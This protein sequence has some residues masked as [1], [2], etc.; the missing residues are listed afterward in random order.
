MK[1]LFLV[2]SFS[3]F[4][5]SNLVAQ[6]SEKIIGVY[7]NHND[8]DSGKLSYAIDCNI[9]KNKIILNDLLNKSYI[10]IKRNDSVY[11]IRKKT[12]Y[13][14]ET[15]GTQVYRFNGKRELLLLNPGEEILI[16]KLLNARIADD[17]KINVTNKYFCIND[18]SSPEK[19]T[20][21]NLKNAFTGNDKFRRLVDANFKYNMELGTFDNENHI[22]KIN[23]LLKESMH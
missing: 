22:F 10:T 7:E 20:I 1:N 5:L 6:T 11:K 9:G 13:G 18:S 4:L 17:S 2:V 15:C 21:K 3:S 16:Y 8:F 12:L 19:L 14:Y 23:S